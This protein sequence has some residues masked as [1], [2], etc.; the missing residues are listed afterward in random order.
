MG[1]E[2]LGKLCIDGLD[3]VDLLLGPV[4]GTWE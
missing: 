4:V 2:Q 1:K 3:S